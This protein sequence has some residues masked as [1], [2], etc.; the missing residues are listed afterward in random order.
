MTNNQNEKF[1]VW[2]DEENKIIRHWSRGKNDENLAHDSAQEVLAIKQAHS[3]AHG[4]LV[5]V[6]E[7]TTVTGGGRQEYG[8]LVKQLDLKSAFFGASMVLKVVVKMVFEVSGKSTT[9]Q[10]FETE[11]EALKWLKNK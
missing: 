11:E 10:M 9:M 2:W 5:D 1:K 7:I 8:N 3:D 6:S 4:F